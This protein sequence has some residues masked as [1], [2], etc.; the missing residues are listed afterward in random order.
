MSEAHKALHMAV[1]KPR[2]LRLVAHPSSFYVFIYLY[3]YIFYIPPP[4]GSSDTKRDQTAHKATS[5]VQDYKMIN[6][7]ASSAV[8]SQR[9]SVFVKAQVNVREDESY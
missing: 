4:E 1:M 7:A 8:N 2:E 9:A 3:I 5:I 6:R